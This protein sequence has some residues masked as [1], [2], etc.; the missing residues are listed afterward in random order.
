MSGKLVELLEDIDYYETEQASM[1]GKRQEY[2]CRQTMHASH[3]GLEDASVVDHD[4]CLVLVARWT[5]KCAFWLFI[6]H[7]ARQ[8]MCRRLIN[9]SNP[10][11]EHWLN[12]GERKTYEWREEVIIVR[13]TDERERYEDFPWWWER[14]D[15]IPRSFFQITEKCI[16]M[17]TTLFLTSN[18]DSSETCENFLL[19]PLACRWPSQHLVRTPS[20]S[21]FFIIGVESGPLTIP[22]TI[23]F[24]SLSLFLSLP[25]W[26]PLN[27]YVLLTLIYLRERCSADE[28]RR[29]PRWEGREKDILSVRFGCSSNAGRRQNLLLS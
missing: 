3:H 13:V 24:L 20:R 4:E 15:V 23:C 9:K 19:F 14:Q 7:C 12:D 28:G 25:P 21:P 1:T 29:M 18:I 11:M 27:I 5:K 26:F 6:H 22:S 8:L 16:S 10:A 2:F 17:P